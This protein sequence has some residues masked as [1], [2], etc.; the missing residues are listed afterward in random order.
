MYRLPSK[1]ATTKMNTELPTWIID[2]IKNNNS[3]LRPKSHESFERICEIWPSFTNSYLNIPENSELGILRTHSL[4]DLS[5]QYE[6]PLLREFVLFNTCEQLHYFSIYQIRELGLSL[7]DSLESG[8][9]YVAGITTRAMLEVVCV[10]YWSFRRI[11][12]LFRECFKWLQVA[13]KTKSSKER[14]KLNKKYSEN[15]Y[16]IATLVHE[17]N[18]ATS[19]D[20]GVYLTQ[21]GGSMPSE[22]PSKINTNEAIKDIASKSKLPLTEVYSV[23]SEFVHPNAGSKMLVINT[24]RAHYRLMDV[25]TVGNNRHNEEAALFYVDHLAE[26]LYYSLTLSLTLSDRF[27]RLLNVLNGFVTAASTQKHH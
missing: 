11:D 10:N 27:I 20:W 15:L 2:A 14:E 9:F 24:K 8:R 18:T 16:K 26:G 4:D 17:A 5:K 6:T 1:Q 25:V 21:F 13:S 22:P 12:D 19:L 3:K 23:L 7:I